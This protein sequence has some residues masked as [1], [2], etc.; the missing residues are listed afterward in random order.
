VNHALVIVLG[1]LLAGVLLAVLLGRKWCNPFAIS[2]AIG[3]LL[4]IGTNVLL[5]ACVEVKVCHPLGDAGIVYTLHPLLGVPVF[6]VA[7]RLAAR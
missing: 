6:W 4:F 2:V 7:A 5:S 3:A 1:L